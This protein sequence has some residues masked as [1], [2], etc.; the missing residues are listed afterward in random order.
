MGCDYPGGSASYQRFDK[1][2]I[3]LASYIGGKP[4][5][6]V[7]KTEING[8]K[9]MYVW[10]LL[11]YRDQR[12][13]FPKDTAKEVVDFFNDPYNFY[14]WKDLIPVYKAFIPYLGVIL[15]DSVQ[16]DI[17]GNMGDMSKWND[18]WEED[19]WPILNAVIDCV[20][21]EDTWYAN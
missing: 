15:N 21:Y 7:P 6:E 19:C 4:A 3:K 1:M 18:T 14:E 12:F 11:P 10:G 9:I 20:R 13:V 16:R 17:A 8:E 2:M 5:N